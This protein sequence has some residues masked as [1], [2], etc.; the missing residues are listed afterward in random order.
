MINIIIAILIFIILLLIITN[1]YVIMAYNIQRQYHGQ[2][3]FHQF[4]FQHKNA[5]YEGFFVIPS[6]PIALYLITKFYRETKPLFIKSLSEYVTFTRLNLSNADIINCDYC[7]LVNGL[8]KLVIDSA[9]QYITSNPQKIATIPIS[10]DII[11]FVNLALL[12][13]TKQITDNDVNDYISLTFGN[14]YSSFAP[15]I[16]KRL[17]VWS[18][19]YLSLEQVEMRFCPFKSMGNY[20]RNT[21]PNFLPINSDTIYQAGK[22]LSQFD[23]IECYLCS[24]VLNQQMDKK[25]IVQDPTQSPMLEFYNF[26]LLQ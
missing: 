11:E 3:Y 6:N 15:E 22:I 21:N 23:T 17:F 2:S 4:I 9:K 24:K 12:M 18:N 14:K 8:S 5:Y 7:S 19:F 1:K 26:L 20:Y 16:Y 13:R 25:Y 10:N